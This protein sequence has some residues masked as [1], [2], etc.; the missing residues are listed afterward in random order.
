VWNGPLD[1]GWRSGGVYQWWRQIPAHR[2]AGS[3]AERYSHSA[4]EH[5]PS[6]KSFRLK[7]VVMFKFEGD[8]IA[9]ESIY[10][11]YASQLRQLGIADLT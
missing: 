7:I 5:P 1:T 8:H 10:L 11:D 2:G 4:E 3:N 6:G 9:S